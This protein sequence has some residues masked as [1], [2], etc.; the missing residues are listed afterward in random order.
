[1]P[2]LN[3]SQKLLENALQYYVAGRFS[4]FAQLH[5]TTGHQFHHAIEFALKGGLVHLDEHIGSHHNIELFWRRFTAALDNPD[6][7][8]L[9]HTIRELHR[10]ES[11]RYP[12]R[13]L[14]H[15]MT[16]LMGFKREAGM[17]IETVGKEPPQY[18][19][20]L[21]EIDQVFGAI[22]L[23]TKLNPDFFTSML[24]RE[25]KTYLTRENAAV[26]FGLCKAA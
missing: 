23:A 17:G 24:S 11:I 10:F 21:E 18:D 5:P 1:M 19:L 22:F 15:G 8:K 12:D 16:S 25:A 7:D 9:G 6:L 20:Y 13:I 14:A 3:A 4:F 26:P 2:N